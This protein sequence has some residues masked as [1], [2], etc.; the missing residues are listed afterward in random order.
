MMERKRLKDKILLKK[1]NTFQKSV[2]ISFMFSMVGSVLNYL[3][4]I[5][6]GNMLSVEEF[7]VYNSVNAVIANLAII[8]TPLSIIICQSTAASEG[9]LKRNRGLY[10]QVFL[11]T[12]LLMIV[13]GLV[14]VWLYPYMV[15][16]FG[17]NSMLYWQILLITVNVSG[18]YN[19]VYSLIQGLKRFV[20]Y[21]IIGNVLIVLKL[22][23]SIFNVKMSW[24]LLGII[25]AIMLSY[26]AIIIF[27]V[28]F[29]KV[30]L[31]K[32][33]AS[34]EIRYLPLNQIV[35]MY[36]MAFLIQMLASFYINGGDIILLNLLF[37]EREAGLYSSAVMLGKISLY[38]ISVISVVLLPTAAG[39]KTRGK[40]TEGVLYKCLAVCLI[41]SL[42]YAFFLITIGKN[43]IP[44]LLG[45]AYKDAF[46]MVPYVVVF[47]IPLGLLSTVHSY[48]LGV[49]K[50]KAY[51]IIS[52][53]VTAVVII[54]IWKF[55]KDVK[56]VPVI[57]GCGVSV[58]LV[59]SLLINA[60]S[61]KLNSKEIANESGKT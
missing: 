48:F 56:L 14:G 13:M 34:E 20:L 6:M 19:I 8:F 43:L 33:P 12:F 32:E 16:K 57:L 58:I 5:V 40:R 54:T 4:Q 44:I 10:R 37:S 24:G 15:G 30:L 28:V 42:V 50:L 51:T 17:V 1:L 55:T 2:M 27:A 23:I 60:V 52:A 25:C 35:K 53:I 3:F 31:E 22:L 21:G 46:Q 61:N 29:I 38:V 41:F 18:M 26:L 59:V 7:G 49:G 45:N 36:G 47:T 9:H 39:D 11:I